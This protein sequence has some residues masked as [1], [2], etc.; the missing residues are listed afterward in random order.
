MYHHFVRDGEPVWNAAKS[1]SAFRA[2]IEALLSAGFTPVFAGD[3]VGYVYSQAELPEK[4]VMITI[5]DG[6]QSNYDI[7]F[8]VLKEL[9]AKATIS[10]IGWSIGLSEAPER[11]ATMLPHFSKEAAKEMYLSGLVDIQNHTHD[12]HDLI[13]NG[14]T[15]D[16]VR[17]NNDEPLA[18][19]Q[20]FI[21]AD[22]A[23]M[24]DIFLEMLGHSPTVFTYPFGKY[25]SE[26][27]KILRQLG[28]RVTLTL[29]S[30]FSTIVQGEP[31]SL[32][33]LNRINV[34]ENLTGAV[35]VEEIVKIMK[36]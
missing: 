29:G 20:T 7:A 30:K 19:Y 21:D 18:D 14:A 16:G 24:N 13:K 23:L 9:N 10:V 2:D 33:G 32:F 6:Y 17:I 8:P 34:D 12:M 28:Y 11:R 3:L 36:K 35:L 22:S 26:S 1:E 4:P 15:H 31:S 27:E 25:T 5:D